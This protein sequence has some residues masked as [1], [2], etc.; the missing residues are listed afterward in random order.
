MKFSC[1]FWILMLLLWY[2]SLFHVNMFIYW[3]PLLKCTYVYVCRSRLN[4]FWKFTVVLFTFRKKFTL[5][6]LFYLQCM[7]LICMILFRCFSKLNLLLLVIHALRMFLNLSPYDFHFFLF[8]QLVIAFLE[9]ILTR[10]ALFLLLICY[11][12]LILSANDM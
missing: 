8:S 7:N 11:Y 6:A 4:F 9:L 10:L 12:A 1:S 3:L 2:E 5:N